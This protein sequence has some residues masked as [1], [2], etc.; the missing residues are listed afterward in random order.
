M[1]IKKEG[2]NPLLYNCS[3]YKTEVFV[4]EQLSFLIFYKLLNIFWMIGDDFL[5]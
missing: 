5:T 3:F 1:Q 2:L 4:K